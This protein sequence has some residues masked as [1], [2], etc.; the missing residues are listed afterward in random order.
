MINSNFC[1]SRCSIPYMEGHVNDAGLG[2]LGLWGFLH[3]ECHPRHHDL[4]T[5]GSL[6]KLLRISFGESFSGPRTF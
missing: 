5:V 6:V 1:I 3:Y 2:G 4:V